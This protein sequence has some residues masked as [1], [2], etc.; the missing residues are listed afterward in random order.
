MGV[1][2][3]VALDSVPEKAG[4]KN[5]KPIAPNMDLKCKPSPIAPS[6]EDCEQRLSQV[7]LDPSKQVLL[8]FETTDTT[9][10]RSQEGLLPPGPAVPSSAP[11]AS[12]NEDEDDDGDDEVFTN[13]TD[14]STPADRR[15]TPAASS[16]AT[17][18]QSLS[19]SLSSEEKVQHVAEPAQEMVVAEEPQADSSE[20]SG[21]PGEGK[22]G[23]DA[24]FTPAN[25]DEGVPQKALV[26][27]VVEEEVDQISSLEDPAG[28]AEA[29]TGVQEEVRAEQAIPCP[30]VVGEE[31]EQGTSP[32]MECEE[33]EA[34]HIDKDET[35]MATLAPVDPLA[36]GRPALWNLTLAAKE[37]HQASPAKHRTPEVGTGLEVAQSPSGRTRGTWSP[38]ASPSSSILKKAQK[39]AL[40]EDA[41]ISPLVKVNA[42]QRSLGLR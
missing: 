20:T 34:T 29:R 25:Q 28:S 21:V 15:S 19:V 41:A 39:R 36:G 17:A 9:T 16:E 4:T 14:L 42:T 33:D 24:S 8:D 30:Q 12:S 7:K 6:H 31:K 32:T 11:N 37:D 26:K 38:S 22:G 23:E 35:E 13:A 5:T 10:E 1:T 3:I 2:P 18:N 27:L 40:E